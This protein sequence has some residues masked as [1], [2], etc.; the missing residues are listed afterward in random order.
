MLA[1]LAVAAQARGV[2]VYHLNIGQ[3]DFETPAAI[4]Q[5]I[6]AF[7]EPTI[8][9]APSQGLPAVLRAWRLYYAG[10]GMDL[11]ESQLIVTVGG[12]E[13]IVLA[14]MCAADPGDE[15][16]VFDPSYTNYC[17]FAAAAA[18]A[19]SSI[20]L[21][22]ATGFHLPPA[23]VL[24]AAISPRTRAILVCN[25]NNPTGSVYTAGELRTVLD[26]AVRHNLFVI[27]DEVY[28]E[29]VF[30]GHTYT[31]MLTLPGAAERVILVDSVSKRFNAC[32]ARI[33]CLA[34]Y[35]A[36]VMRAALHLAQAR[37]CAPTVE[38][39]SVVPLLE[40]AA[41]Y[42]APLAA[43]YQRR[44][45]AAVAALRAIPG[46]R[47]TTPE[48]AFYM[49][50]ELPVDDAERFARWLL[51]DFSDAG[52]TVM[53]AP[54]RGFYVTPGR[55]TR[56]V[57]LAFVLEEAALARAI[58]VLGHALAVYPGR[59]AEGDAGHPGSTPASGRAAG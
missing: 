50:V 37:L 53:V 15:V 54:L 3:P 26:V 19:L 52:E 29:F 33:G 35:N 39:L 43:A 38:Q 48:G 41:P 44:R 4:K 36:D 58:A 34:S 32:G 46:V 18:V 25:P 40:D 5:A 11:D 59:D 55:G 42:T 30:D 56:A 47:F 49:I 2:H 8:A 23:E 13:A 31:G 7:A 24:E 21:D 27:A 9:Y 22:P 16:I 10:W 17:G 1:P 28:R 57:R 14:M 51:E 12:S 20:A 6:H 45:D